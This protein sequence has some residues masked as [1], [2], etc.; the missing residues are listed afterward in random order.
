MRLIT[1]N[2]VARFY[3]YVVAMRLYIDCKKEYETNCSIIPVHFQIF[4][5]TNFQISIHRQIFKSTHSQIGIHS[6]IFKLI[7]F[8]IIFHRKINTS[9][10]Y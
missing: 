7:N 8:Q 2:M 10:T 5:S 3:K 6:Q 1:K 9:I 4:K